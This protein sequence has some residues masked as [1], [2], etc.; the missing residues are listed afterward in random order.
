[1]NARSPEW[2]AA[3]QA[4]VS[5]T[6]LPVILGLS[7]YKSEAALAREK[8]SGER[9]EPGPEQA[10]RMRIG[11][12]MEPIIRAEYEIET[13]TKLR[14]VKRLIAH[15]RI[16]WALTSLDFERVGERYI[17]ETKASTSSRWGDELP[18]DVEA[19]VRWQMGT[20]G[21]PV[22][23]VAALLNGS[24]LR[25]YTVE[26]EAATFDGL[27]DV[28]ADFRRRLETDGPFAENAASIKA[29]Y[30]V[31]DGSEMVADSELAEAV[32]ALLSWRA[33][34]SVAQ[35][36]EEALE[37]AI[38]ARM[39]DATRLI[40]DDFAVTWKRTRDVTT[41]DWKSLADGLL[42]Q[43]AETEREALVGIN[44]TVRPGFRPFRVTA[45]ESKE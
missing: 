20:A 22:A 7:P 8:L 17:V 6:D 13:G 25:L 38:K 3:R 31:D 43:L 32:H 41:T 29:R 4:G 39:A 15:P 19:Q 37:V 35:S 9:E 40:G 12:A 24:R 30:P 26:H 11:L 5:S 14:R 1:M 36:T 2:L 16:S 28:A 42:R 34:R 33:Q 23:D 21:Y 27:L 45:K 18:Q 10:R 44:S